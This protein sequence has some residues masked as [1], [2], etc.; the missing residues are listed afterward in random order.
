L[1]ISIKKKVNIGFFLSLTIILLLIAYTIYLFKLGEKNRDLSKITYNSIYQ[2]QGLHLKVKELEV[3]K[4]EYVLTKDKETK[5]SYFNKLSEIQTELIRISKSEIYKDDFEQIENFKMLESILHSKLNCKVD[6]IGLNTNTESIKKNY[7]IIY[8]TEKDLINSMKI[9]IE[10]VVQK[11]KNQLDQ[12]Q[13]FEQTTQSKIIIF[14]KVGG[15]FSVIL[16][17]IL[18]F[19]INRDINLK[20]IREE[21]LQQLSFSDEMT[22]LYNRRG[23]IKMGGKRF[24][25]AVQFNR[26]LY[27]FFIDMDGLKKINDSLGH[28]YGDKAIIS[29]SNLLKQSFRLTDVIARMGGDEFAVIM[30]DDHVTPETIHKRLLKKINDFNETKRNEFH[31]SF[32]LG[33]E[34]FDPTNPISIEEMLKIADKKM[35]KQKRNEKKDRREKES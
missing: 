11:E 27:L 20:N 5:E 22:G 21:E 28:E 26:K 8:E 3:L 19:V 30:V 2:I 31:L 13:E 6:C 33:V 35:Y 15:V 4:L 18:I 34:R 17:L 9:L 7:E 10:K 16:F 29:L 24:E 25:E 14:I 32:S 1:K 23:F 12:I